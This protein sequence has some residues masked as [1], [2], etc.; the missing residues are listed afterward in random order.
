[1]KSLRCLLIYT[2]LC[3]FS[4]G[5]ALGQSV[6]ITGRVSA[7]GSEKAIVGAQVF[8][9]GTHINTTTNA[10]GEYSLPPVK[11]GSYSV[12]VFSLG[13]KSQQKIVEV[14]EGEQL[15]LDF[16]LEELKE[17]LDE[18]II[19]D[20][21]AN[22]GGI[23]RLKAVEGTAIYEAKKSEVIVLDDIT[24]N[25]ATNNSRQIYSKVPGLNIW[26]SDGA[27]LQLGIGGRGLSPNRTS[28]FNTRQNGY[29]ISADAL[30]Y[31]ESYY[32]P[33]AEAV[34]KIQIV[35]G[36]AS[37]QYGTQFGGMLNFVMKKG[38]T[39]TPL[40]FTTRQTIGSFGLFNSFNSL[41]GTTGKLNYYTFYQRKQGNGWRPNSEFEVNTFFT[42]FNF[43]L[44][45]KFFISLEYT[46][47]NYLAQQPG[48]LKDVEFLAD[49]QMSFR[50]RNWFGVNWNL[51]AVQMEYRFSDKTRLETRTFGL[52]AGRDALG[53]L[54]PL[55]RPIEPNRKLIQD[56]FKN[57]G[58]ETRI[59][60]HY[61]ISGEPA[62]MLAGVRY[63]QGLTHK[64]QGSADSGSD[65]NFRFL[66]PDS[67]F[68][69]HLFPNRNLA[70]FV[71]NIFPIT[72]KL[73]ITP[74]LRYEWIDTRSDGYYQKVLYKQDQNGLPVETTV[75]EIDTMQRQRPV[76][77]AGLGL[78]YKPTATTELYANIS[79]NYRAINF[80]D[81][82][83][84]N[85]NMVVDPNLKDESGYSA[86]LGWRG[87]NSWLNY[88]ISLFYLK[89][90]DKIS[91]IY[92]KKNGTIVRARR[93]ISDAHIAG[94]ES[95][96]QADLM[97]LL[98]P[99]PT[100]SL[101]IFVNLALIEGR[102]FN[103]EQVAFRNKRVELV[104]ASNFKTGLTFRKKA[105]SASW[106]YA[107]VG[108]QY[109]DA[110]NTPNPVH[111]AVIGPVPAFN[112]MDL[113]LQYGLKN[114]LFE[115][116]INNLTN[117]MY[118][119]RRA[120]GYPGP[121]IIPSDARSFYLTVGYKFQKK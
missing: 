40:E 31:P 91:S 28:N 113:S 37:L 11:P 16:S 45:K 88:D 100:F 101:S 117:Q 29:D 84:L 52:L 10:K 41:G 55:N 104:P 74:G 103:S 49:P 114:F 26:E 39:Q 120:D 1:M 59:M 109:T 92:E 43:Q 66:N 68:S 69:D 71:E 81:L 60:H 116:G 73:S 115:G 65:P 18:L 32:T 78:S 99:K 64:M 76:W 35:R 102:Y 48:G 105:F 47:M 95:F 38:P 107:L 79:E 33:P 12:A 17:L 5:F 112:V 70:L 13:L 61:N 34:E 24:A 2:C 42:D 67:L 62:V 108:K 9:Q 7:A 6:T 54:Q 22:S 96:V 90:N 4:L 20:K 57:F 72:D 83:V 56:T 93:N 25:L 46:H 8:I 50:D 3:C 87:S 19:S 36:A 97:Q 14:R 119:T 118:F 51:G 23:T 121:G 80:T 110:D 15:Q 86:D 30:G 21:K 63:Y 89:Y 85:P 53:D 82:R 106:Q 27:G 58:N 98:Q 44:T 94:M 77:L 111:S 75:V